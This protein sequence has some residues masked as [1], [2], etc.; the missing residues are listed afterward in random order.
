[1]KILILN[2]S[3]RTNGS[4]ATFLDKIY[5]VLDNYNDVEL[6]HINISN[7]KLNYCTGCSYC[8]KSGSCYMKDDLE[9]LSVEIS[10]SDGLILATPTYV[11]NVSGQMKT[12][13]DRGHFVLEQLL[14]DKYAIS[15]VT[16]DN[17]GGKAASNVLAKLLSYSGAKVSNNIIIKNT[18]DYDK[19]MKI[20]DNNAHKLYYDI[21]FK[22]KYFFQELKHSIIFNIGIKPYIMK[23]KQKYDGVINKH[24]KVRNLI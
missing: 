16:Y 19:I 24:W 4:T 12:V 11:S 3:P 1:M 21:K 14:Y 17:Y 20:A 5:S 22:R 23:N 2:A 18:L 8:Y 10:K 7:L 13:I 9:K 15:I 6:K